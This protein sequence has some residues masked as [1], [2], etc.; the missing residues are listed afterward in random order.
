MESASFNPTTEH[1]LYI[2]VYQTFLNI[3]LL[4][5]Y[6][7]VSVVIGIPDPPTNVSVSCD[8]ISMTVSWRSEFNG[9]DLQTF[10]V[11]WW[12]EFENEKAYSD[13]F[14]IRGCIT[15]PTLPFQ[16]QQT[17]VIS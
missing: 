12:K 9:G 7:F 14:W 8:I 2:V 5:K 1:V 17:H 4:I 15:I 3:S 10:I 13:K 11:L 16:S 6:Y